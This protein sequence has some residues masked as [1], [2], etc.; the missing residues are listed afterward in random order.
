M[1]GGGAL[2]WFLVFLLVTAPV[3]ALAPPAR[4]EAP[5]GLP[6]AVDAGPED[7]ADAGPG[8]GTR[9]D[10]P[11]A[12]MALTVVP[13]EHMSYRLLGHRRVELPP[14]YAADMGSGLLITDYPWGASSSVS[15]GLTRPENTRLLV[16][17]YSADALRA[18]T[19]NSSL[20]GGSGYPAELTEV[21]GPNGTYLFTAEPWSGGGTMTPCDGRDLRLPVSSVLDVPRP[22]G[23]VPLNLLVPLT[24]LGYPSGEDLWID[25]DSYLDGSD[26]VA[27]VAVSRYLRTQPWTAFLYFVNLSAPGLLDVTRGHDVPPSLEVPWE[28]PLG[29]RFF[30]RATSDVLFSNRIKEV[31][32]VYSYEFSFVDLANLTWKTFAAPA[33][34]VHWHGR[35]GDLLY[36]LIAARSARPN[37]ET[38]IFVR[39]DLA[40][41]RDFATL[42]ADAI[43]ELWRKT[44][45]EGVTNYYAVPIVRGDSL[46]VL[47]GSGGYEP[48]WGP[49]FDRMTTYGLYDGSLRS[50]E[51]LDLRAPA[52][53][54]RDITY[55]HLPVRAAYGSWL[56]DLDG[57]VV[58]ALN[59]TDLETFAYQST[60][61]VRCPNCHTDFYVTEYGPSRI[62]LLA[63]GLEFTDPTWW[64]FVS[65]EVNIGDP[66]PNEPPTAAF[67][68]SPT[69]YPDARV[70]FDATASTDADGV[71]GSYSWDFGDG[72]T[73]AGPQVDHAYASAGARTV[74]LTVTGNGGLQDT[75]TRVVTVR[76]LV[77]HD[78]P[79]GFRLP[80]PDNWTA[81][82]GLPDAELLLEGPVF[83]GTA[84]TVDV[85][86]DADPAVA[87]TV[88]YLDGQ[89]AAELAEIRGA[90]PDAYMD[91]NPTH[92]NVGGH[93]AA[94]VL[95][96]FDSARVAETV[97][98]VA[99]AD[100]GRLWVLRFAVDNRLQD[101]MDPL[102]DRMLAGF[103]ITL[104]TTAENL[105][106][107]V[108]V[109]PVAVVV[110]IIAVL[111][112]LWLRWRKRRQPSPDRTAPARAMPRQCPWC[113]ALP[114]RADDRFCWWC[115]AP[116]LPSAPGGGA[117]APPSGG[118][119]PPHP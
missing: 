98:V 48:A 36:L 111:L 112:A 1:G 14:G 16:Y 46:I 31:N 70:L 90:H 79:A 34:D 61:Q 39:V 35:S 76:G 3:A 13:P 54:L 101:A 95:V 78:N 23:L 75:A 28:A 110:P 45:W 74:T 44:F 83:N 109:V 51:V 58:E 72:A 102:F 84:S 71:I 26:L 47:E 37:E 69:A 94:I 38:Y 27:Y 81:R 80:V 114:S 40:R 96:R 97:A 103:E 115:G 64:S 93:L 33:F 32:G 5:A 18:L 62:R 22:S 73:G 2:A 55:P 7:P 60:G 108:L 104:S 87:E 50:Q 25:H 85:H 11:P 77:L 4:G 63:E 9:S 29:C 105:V 56:L 88:A 89:V 49:R 15:P 116:L 117:T 86:S 99:S 113:A 6:L 67:T 107:L 17:N 42:D 59:L 41:A 118:H 65:L 106:L 119:P 8:G 20:P 100:H 82:T 21:S 66:P 43:T 91:G 30:E 24:Q 10:N 12:P 52:Y 68:S 57:G 92:R 19:Y 53:R